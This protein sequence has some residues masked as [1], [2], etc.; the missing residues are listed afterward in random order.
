ME[1]LACTLSR[2]RYLE[3]NGRRK[4]ETVLCLND[5]RFPMRCNVAQ[6]LNLAY[7][8]VRDDRVNHNLPTTAAELLSSMSIRL[9]GLMVMGVLFQSEEAMD[10]NS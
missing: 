1:G 7:A 3:L 4:S 9:L 6:L 8:S 5:L 2:F 10:L